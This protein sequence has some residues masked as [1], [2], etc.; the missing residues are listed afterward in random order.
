MAPEQARG[1]RDLTPATDIFSLGC[2]LYECLT[3]QPPFIADHIAAVLVRILCE[4]PVPIEER[5]PGISPSLAAL[6]SHLLT[7][8][9]AQR[10]ADA[11]ILRNELLILGDLPEPALAATMVSPQPKAE[12]FA[13]Q[14]QSLFCVVLAAPVETEIGLGAVSISLAAVHLAKQIF[15]T[16]RNH[17][18][19]L[20]GAG[21]TGEQTARMLL[22]EG[23]APKLLVCNRTQERADALASQFGGAALPG[24]PPQRM[25]SARALENSTLLRLNGKEVLKLFESD[26]ASGFLVMRRLSSLIARF[27]VAPG[28]K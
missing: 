7:K 23:D 9:P 5:R 20:I 3:G 10:I 6:L 28:A 21:E 14:E 8:D 17:V 2:V 16:L 24:T 22:Q 19:L 26:P 11:A 12:S 1:S 27:L 4:E 25:A 18:V 15:Q 13:E